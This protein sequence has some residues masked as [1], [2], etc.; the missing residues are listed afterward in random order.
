MHPNSLQI[1]LGFANKIEV[2]FILQEDI[3]LTFESKSDVC[4]TISYNN[5]GY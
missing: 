1:A 5:G 2:Y 3:I 4:N